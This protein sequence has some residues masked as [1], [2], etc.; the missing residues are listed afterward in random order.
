MQYRYTILQAQCERYRLPIA[1]LLFSILQLTVCGPTATAQKIWFESNPTLSSNT[2]VEVLPGDEYEYFARGATSIRETLRYALRFGPAGMQVDSESGLVRWAAMNAGLFEV[3]ISV[4][5]ASDPSIKAVQR[6]QVVV[7][8]V[9]EHP[10]CEYNARWVGVGGGFPWSPPPTVALQNPY[11]GVS[12]QGS[13]YVLSKIPAVAGGGQHHNAT[14]SRWT[15]GAW[16]VVGEMPSTIQE[17]RSIITYKDNIYVAGGAPLSRPIFQ[18]WD[19]GN[20]WTS[21]INPT[22][23]GI[24]SGSINGIAVSGDYLYV[25]GDFQTQWG[26]KTMIGKWDGKDFSFLKV[27][28]GLVTLS[29]LVEW[30][31]DI[32]VTSQFTHGNPNDVSYFARLDNDATLTPVPEVS[33]RPLIIQK[34]VSGDKGICLM[35]ADSSQKSLSL[36]DG[37]ELTTLPNPPD[38]DSPIPIG[39]YGGDLYAYERVTETVVDQ[40]PRGIDSTERVT[41]Y[42][43]WRWDG[44]FWHPLSELSAARGVVVGSWRDI[45]ITEHKNSLYA[46]GPFS[47]SCGTTLDGIAQ[48]CDRGNCAGISGTVYQDSDRD[49]QG[50]QDEAGVEGRMIEILPGPYFV[51]TNKDGSY[52]TTVPPGIYSVNLVP[53]HH[54]DHPCGTGPYPISLASSNS[55]AEDVDFFVNGLSVFEFATNLSVTIPNEG[56]ELHYTLTYENSGTISGPSI[57][58]F[59]HDARLAF[60]SASIDPTSRNGSSLEWDIADLPIGEKDSITIVLRLRSGLHQREDLCAVVEVRPQSMDGIQLVIDNERELCTA[61]PTSYVIVSLNGG[62]ARPGIMISY[63]L[64]YHSPG[65]T[66][67]TLS[68]HYDQRFEFVSGNIEPQRL[69]DGRLDWDFADLPAGTKVSMHLVLRVPENMQL[70]EEVCATGIAVSAIPSES[71]W[72]RAYTDE[73]CTEITNAYDPNDIRVEPHFSL[74]ELSEATLRPQDTVLTYLVR[75]QNTG[76][77]TAFLVV[78]KDTLQHSLL[79]IASIELGAASHPFDFSVNDAGELTW[80][81]DNIL[82]PDSNANEA[83]SHGYFKYRVHLKKGLVPLTEIPNRVAIYF[84]YNEPVLTNTVVS[85]TNELVLSVGNDGTLSDVLR[86]YPNPARDATTVHFTNDERSHVLLRMLNVKGSVVREL[87]NTELEAGEHRLEIETDNLESGTYFIVLEGR[88]KKEILPIVVGY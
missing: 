23:Y 26:T 51:E 72:A 73:Y 57:I 76:N 35:V 61:V 29:T 7:K 20:S 27:S 74:G 87:L 5:L 31:G 25:I 64:V 69:S 15:G 59:D 30:Q 8:E 43:M 60:Q 3:E 53:H 2:P 62:R 24:Q 52:A 4:A 14:L 84:D 39:F 37:T 79:D 36:W 41:G 66:M 16:Q 47:E 6:W 65:P 33:G 86:V 85:V 17:A 68:F 83:Q 54:W 18:R 88:G 77:D 46:Y 58:S 38:A 22:S 44:A 50:D 12:F 71:G 75:F 28:D 21:I 13:L 56:R 1:V 55:K 67:Q 34:I 48:F 81:F 49:C 63:A 9:S 78:V 11:R 45:M 32:Y 40:T 42:L 19:G 80:T 82:L 10:G 70:G